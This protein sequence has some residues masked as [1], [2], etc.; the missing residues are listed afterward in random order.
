MSNFTPPSDIS[1]PTTWV[2]ALYNGLKNAIASFLN[3]GNL[4]NSNFSAD[5]TERLAGSKVDLGS[6]VTASAHHTRHEPGGAD[7]VQDIDIL[8]TGI[9]LSAHAARHASGGADPLLPGSVTQ[10]MLA[11]SA[12][13]DSNLLRRKNRQSWLAK[14]LGL[15]LDS[16]PNQSIA[17][18]SSTAYPQGNGV[19]R[20]G[21]VYFACVGTDSVAE[22]DFTA[23]TATDIALISGDNPNSLLLVG[24]DIYVLC[25]GTK[26]IK[27]IDVNNVVTTVIAALNVAP[28][29]T[30]MDYL[31][32]M[33]PNSDGTIVFIAY[34]IGGQTNPTHVA[35]VALTGTPGPTHDFSSGQA[36]SDIGIPWF[37]K[38]G[39]TEHVIFVDTFGTGLLY[40]RLAADLTAVDTLVFDNN[41][42]A[43]DGEHLVVGDTTG[44][45][46]YLI[47]P[48]RMKLAA[49][50]AIPGGNG[51][52]N[53]P[54]RDAVYFDGKAAYFGARATGSTQ[55]PCVI[56]VPVPN[57]GGGVTLMIDDL[58]SAE[59]VLGFA[60]DGQFLYVA[61]GSLSAN[62]KVHRM[63]L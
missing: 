39:A 63:M 25:S 7:E 54:F 18:S 32:G 35:R 5:P 48:W 12:F 28:C 40:R 10:A 13:A 19:V 3:N 15:V 4:G 60:T 21:K 20:N 57:Y 11:L 27:K 31:E 24:T 53:L 50:Y 36:T 44:T 41:R 52:D 30:N 16:A 1:D 2:A 26:K 43:Y 62:G 34:K 58:G 61:G 29:D 55:K 51:V 37:I 49:T 38:R 23:G 59:D 17:L 6:G 22:V 46:I 56:R 33:C 8:N 9:L 42:A 14:G 45:N 47:D